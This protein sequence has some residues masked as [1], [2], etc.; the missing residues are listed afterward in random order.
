MLAHSFLSLPPNMYMYQ[1]SFIPQSLQS[2][3]INI[4]CYFTISIFLLKNVNNYFNCLAIILQPR[5]HLEGMRVYSFSS[6]V[7]NSS[8]VSHKTNP[9][10]F[11]IQMEKWRRKQGSLLPP[12]ATALVVLVFSVNTEYYVNPTQM[13]SISKKEVIC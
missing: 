2:Y 7:C 9:V 13:L 4:H 6:S 1:D 11:R 3:V 12:H 8:G 5:C 10:G